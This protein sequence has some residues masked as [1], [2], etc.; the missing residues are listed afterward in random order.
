MKTARIKFLALWVAMLFGWA[1]PGAHAADNGL[2]LVEGE[3]SYYVPRHISR[4][5]AEQIA[6]ERARI[7]AIARE[8]GTAMSMTTTQTTLSRSGGSESDDFYMSASSLV[9]GEWVETIGSPVFSIRL[10]NDDIVI[11]CRVKGKARALNQA[12]A[13]LDVHLLKN[14]TAP[15]AESSHFFS[16]DKLFLSFASPVNGYLTVYLEDADHVVYRMLPFFGEKKTSTPVEADKHYIFFAS[17][18]GDSEQYIM[19]AE[20]TEH[21]NVYVIFS[22]NEYIKPIDRSPRE[23][24]ALRE[25]S[26]D[27]FRKWIQRVQTLDPKL[28]VINLPIVISNPVTD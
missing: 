9:K 3:Y 21:N 12:H 27:D 16:G 18:E 11:S 13:D 6:L 7:G 4:N 2:K 19:T 28:Q 20:G 1:I 25:L 23:E 15:D 24:Q 26:L 14:S 22:P 8:F 5:Q 10:E 17:T